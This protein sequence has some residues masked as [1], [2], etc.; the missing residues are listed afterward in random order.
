MDSNNNKFEFATLN[1]S[2]F[3]PM[4]NM[5]LFFWYCPFIPIK[6][7]ITMLKVYVHYRQNIKKHKTADSSKGSHNLR[8]KLPTQPQIKNGHNVS[9]V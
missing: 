9:I 4:K 3:W 5:K 1:D 2:T 6:Q 7:L 8:M